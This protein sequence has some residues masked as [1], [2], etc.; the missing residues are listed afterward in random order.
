MW[1]M[2]KPA[3]YT[4]HTGCYEV[5]YRDYNEFISISILRYSDIIRKTEND[6]IYILGK[7]LKKLNWSNA[8]IYAFIE[9]LIRPSHEWVN[10]LE[11]NVKTGKILPRI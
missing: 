5:R 4:L 2:N 6:L 8:A 3:L 9:L 10:R 1:K 7:R 11:I